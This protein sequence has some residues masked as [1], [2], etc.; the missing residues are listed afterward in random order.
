VTLIALGALCV[1]A[2]PLA[3][4]R[5]ARELNAPHLPSKWQAAVIGLILI[6]VCGLALLVVTRLRG[7]ETF[8]VTSP[9]AAV[10]ALGCVVA[11]IPT[12]LFLRATRATQRF[13]ASAGAPQCAACAY[14]LAGLPTAKCPECGQVSEHAQLPPLRFALAGVPWNR[15]VAH[16]VLIIA[17]AAIVILQRPEAP[18]RR[19]LPARWL[20]LY[21]DRLLPPGT[22]SLE[23]TFFP[24]GG[25]ANRSSA[26]SYAHEARLVHKELLGRMQKGALSPDDLAAVISFGVRSMS[27]SPARSQDV[28]QILQTAREKK[29]LTP[30]RTRRLFDSWLTYTILARNTC[31]AGEP[32][33]IECVM[34][35]RFRA[36][37]LDPRL[38]VLPISDVFKTEVT[39]LTLGGETIARNVPL[40]MR[41]GSSD[42]TALIPDRS[43]SLIVPDSPTG[44]QNLV[45]ALSIQWMKERLS[46][47]LSLPISEL[48][49]E[50]IPT[51]WTGKA[52]T[53]LRVI[54]PS[55]R[56]RQTVEVPDA[57]KV[58]NERVQFHV[59]PG[60]GITAF[61]RLGKA[62]TYP[63]VFVF[64]VFIPAHEA[65]G[66]IGTMAFARDL[67]NAG[68]YLHSKSKWLSELCRLPAAERRLILHP[69]PPG[70][71]NTPL[72]GPVYDGPDIEVP[73]NCS[74]R[75]R[76]R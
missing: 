4:A 58:I 33:G 38:N 32:L 66:P 50:G 2:L 51:S 22:L 42:Y 10:S 20:L 17:A 5:A 14:P 3:F 25:S 8:R 46:G 31:A 61:E 67:S 27:E 7:N 52:T 23:D 43:S 47:S 55:E 68:P 62:T 75:H 59:D 6:S 35:Q 69:Y 73:V 12:L 26:R 28:E 71:L 48:N 24:R 70:I 45:A 29:L 54:G 21:A 49:A 36:T 16:T 18:M 44:P 39:S 9:S 1:I 72:D 30:E 19:N 65:E 11:L 60:E 74:S 37:L 15:A 76:A 40:K 41:I 63:G 34:H 13:V 64:Q 56:I 57:H 53:Q